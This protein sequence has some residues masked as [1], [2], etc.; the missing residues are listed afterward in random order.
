ML[1]RFCKRILS[2]VFIARMGKAKPKEDIPM[3]PLNVDIPIDLMQLLK[4]AK[5]LTDKPI[6]TITAEALAAWM[7][8]EGI[9]RDAVQKLRRN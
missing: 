7:K 5:A 4:V 2:L 6:R 9:N 1:P 3:V 8:Q